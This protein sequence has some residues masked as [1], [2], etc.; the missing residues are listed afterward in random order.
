MECGCNVAINVVL[1]GEVTNIHSL[2]NESHFASYKPQLV[3][4]LLM[5]AGSLHVLVLSK[6]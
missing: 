3:I 1:A 5:T 2:N 4:A 6:L